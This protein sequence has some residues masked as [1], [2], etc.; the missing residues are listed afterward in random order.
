MFSYNLF[1]VHVNLT[2]SFLDL[3]QIFAYI[4]NFNLEDENFIPVSSSHLPHNFRHRLFC[5]AESSSSL[6]G[7]S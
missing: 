1:P 3:V 7:L 2:E 6:T 4:F 5:Q